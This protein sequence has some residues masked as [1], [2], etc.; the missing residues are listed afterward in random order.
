VT[1]LPLGCV[2]RAFI[3]SKSDCHTGG[4]FGFRYLGS[5]PRSSRLYAAIVLYE[6]LLFPG[7]T[8]ELDEDS[9][10]LSTLPQLP[11]PSQN[12]PLSE[13]QVPETTTRKQSQFCALSM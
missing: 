8:G 12:D 11:L 3:F 2:K 5:Q 7:C 6:I 1:L 4:K 13:H 9:G 10:E